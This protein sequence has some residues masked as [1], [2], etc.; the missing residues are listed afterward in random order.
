MIWFMPVRYLFKVLIQFFLTVI[1]MKVSQI[2]YFSFLSYC[3][4][5]NDTEPWTLRE[6]IMQTAIRE[7]IHC[8]GN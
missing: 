5:N 3:E 8:F 7:G 6:D 4:L 2:E 1:K